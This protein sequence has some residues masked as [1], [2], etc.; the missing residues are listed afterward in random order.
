MSL[1][2]NQLYLAISLG[3]FAIDVFGSVGPV[4]VTFLSIPLLLTAAQIGLAI[5]A[6]QL[7]NA[8]SQPVFGWLADKFGTRWLNPIS[9]IWVITFL[10]LSVLAAQMT[11]DFSLFLI[12]FALGA[13]GSGAFHPQGTMQAATLSAHR[14]ATGTAV[15]FLFGQVGLALGPFLG[16]VILGV[17]G[18]AGIYGMALSTLPLILFF[19]YAAYRNSAQGTENIPTVSLPLPA[20][21]V[22]A[23]ANPAGKIQWWAI[24]LL[25]LL[26]GLRSWAFLGTV[27]FLPKL[28]QDMGWSPT[29]Y[30]SITAVYWLTSAVMGVVAGDWAD[31]WGRRQVVFITLMLGSIPLY[32]LPLNSGWIAFPLAVAVGG[33]MGS[34][35]SIL[36][37]IAQ[38]LLPSA[39]S[40]ASGIT[41]GYLFG[42]GA[43][44]TWSIGQMADV[45]SLVPVIQAGALIGIASAFLALLLPSTRMLPQTRPLPSEPLQET[46]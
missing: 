33:L 1:L 19:I 43:I 38:G 18:L 6:Y 25:T 13:L 44:A 4:L 7:V 21:S 32:F 29:A 12:L 2:R 39:K 34:S 3:H 9:V 17:V 40:L 37:V 23:P 14:S 27:S 16:G 26:I 15:F 41:L 42:I 5:S 35:H 46:Q 30:G 22:E 36:V 10:T 45:W 8:A 11:L 24:S 20:A 28:F 31:R